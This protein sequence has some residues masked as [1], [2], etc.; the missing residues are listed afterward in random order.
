MD[1]AP[2]FSIKPISDA[3]RYWIDA[4]YTE[5]WGSGKVVTRGQLY[6]VAELPGFIAWSE[7]A[8]SGLL[9]YHLSD[10]ELEIVT[11]DSLEPGQGAG[12]ALLAEAIDFSKAIKCQRMWLITTN[13]NTAALRFYQITGFQLV[14]I[15][16]NAI[17]DSRRIKPEIPLVGL[18]GIPI[19]DEIELEYPLT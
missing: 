16:R 3:D 1:S 14:K 12:R 13:D 4:F 18:D 8:R 2:V 7:K 19:R 11:L 17:Q 10:K 9:T 15:H 5:R 6:T